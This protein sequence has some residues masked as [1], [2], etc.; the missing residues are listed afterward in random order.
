MRVAITVRFCVFTDLR[1]CSFA[2]CSVSD[3][4]AK[5][6]KLAQTKAKKEKEKERELIKKR[7][8][9]LVRIRSL[10]GVQLSWLLADRRDCSRP[11]QLRAHHCSLRSRGTNPRTFLLLIFCSSH[12][13]THFL[14]FECTVCAASHDSVAAARQRHLCQRFVHFPLQF[15]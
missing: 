6:R 13:M 7:G 8:P 15:D 3:A 4:D 10:Y 5:A 2:S 14:A 12:L 1:L 11:R 9:L